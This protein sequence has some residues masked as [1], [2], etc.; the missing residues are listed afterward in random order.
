MAAFSGVSQVLTLDPLPPALDFSGAALPAR[1]VV[2]LAEHL[3]SAA[4]GAAATVTSLVLRR[5]GFGSADSDTTLDEAAAAVDAL[6]EL[7][8]SSTRLR[9]LDLWGC[10]L[11]DDDIR[12]LCRGVTGNPESALTTLN[13]GY[14]SVTTAGARVLADC[15]CKAR[16]LRTLTLGSSKLP[17][18]KIYEAGEKWGG[19]VNLSDLSVGPL[20][21][22]VV[23]L[24]ARRSGAITSL[25]VSGNVLRKEGTD[26]LCKEL[27][28]EEQFVR[29]DISRNEIFPSGA[30][31]V[32][33]I[34]RGAG[35]GLEWLSL[36]DNNI[37]NWAKETHA[38]GTIVS[39]AQ[40]CGTLKVLNLEGNVLQDEGAACV[41]ELIANS[42][43]LEELN[44][45]RAQIASDGG[46]AL[47]DAIARAGKNSCL[48]VL[49][50][51]N[52]SLGSRGATVSRKS[53]F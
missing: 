51:G 37:T 46:M 44:L 31:S 28:H 4:G 38:L 13:L 30:S 10:G 8:R 22:I 42:P 52:N 6:A 9:A 19:A 20:S 49:N 39:A 26:F 12:V 40:D 41:A 32:A 23:G 45:S 15:C 3:R 14:N 5:C 29:L 21:A 25:D 48:K 53:E 2:R 27:A 1:D 33:T 7:L 47:G 35:G 16:A 36:A 43:C 34:L 50:L 17:V 24:V 11:T 18:R